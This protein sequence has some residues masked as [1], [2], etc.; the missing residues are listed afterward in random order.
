LLCVRDH[1]TMRDQRAMGESHRDGADYYV[2]NALEATCDA[3]M[4]LESCRAAS[5]GR[6]SSLQLHVTRAIGS[7]R[8]AISELRQARGDDDSIVAHGFVVRT[9]RQRQDN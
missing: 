1:G 9:G 3:L 7:L 6:R 5:S 4:T 8:Q 2:Q